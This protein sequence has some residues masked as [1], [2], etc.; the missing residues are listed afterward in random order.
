MPVVRPA[1]LGRRIVTSWIRAAK[2]N[3]EFRP[4]YTA[5]AAA[6]KRTDRIARRPLAEV[7]TPLVA[8]IGRL[9]LAQDDT[10]TRPYVATFVCKSSRSVPCCVVRVADN[11]LQI[12]VCRATRLFTFGSSFQASNPS[13][14]VLN[15][16][17]EIVDLE[18]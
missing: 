4:C 18:L 3:A 16:L 9:T 11:L 8:G 12:G 2:L 13:L 1:H 6:G 7:V 10:L 17:E 14:E 15:L 5:V